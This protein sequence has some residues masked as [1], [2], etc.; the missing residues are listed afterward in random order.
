M[1]TILARLAASVV[2]GAGMSAL[3]ISTCDATARPVCEIAPTFDAG[4]A[5]TSEI[6]VAPP[7]LGSNQTGDG[8]V[9]RPY[10]TIQYAAARAVPGTAVRVHPGSYAGGSFVT[11]V[12]GTPEAPIWIGGF[13]PRPGE[14]PA[15]PIITGGSEGL[16]LV[17]CAY[18]VVH[19]LEVRNVSSNGINSDDGGE[20]DDPTAAHHQVFRSLVIQ[21]IGG[22][23]NQ[24][25]LKLSGVYNFAVIDCEISRCGGAMSGSGIDMVGC[26]DGVIARTF[27]H[28]LSANAVQA[29]GGTTNID[30]T[31][32]RI[33]NA[34]ERALNI[35]GSTGFEFFRP[36]LSKTGPNAEARNI[37]ATANTIL[38]SNAAVAF[39]GAMDCVFAHNT[40]IEPRRWIMRI[41]QETTSSP[42]YVF[43]ACSNNTFASNIVYFQRGQI[44]T[45]VNIGSNTLPA[46]FVFRNNLWYAHDNPAASTPGLP[47]PETGAVVGVDPMLKDVAGGDY[48]ICASSA[49]AGQG[50]S[51]PRVAGD[52]GGACYRSPP[53]IGAF[54]IPEHPAADFDSSGDLGSADFFAFLSAFFLGDPA[55]DFNADG[56]I[57]SQDFFDFLG[58]FI[59]GC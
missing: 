38:G 15:R 7:P 44:S 30:I 4:R 12:R 49:A 29:K 22:T 50:E 42:P 26:H 40:V 56:T 11:D 6:N 55:S 20:Y 47:S 9:A 45:Y 19:D 31:R 21:D 53:S 2:W 59:S 35:G 27:M 33:E 51:P 54:E 32:C 28:D 37:R 14:P 8:S 34:G 39:V 1:R 13:S 5:P 16:H 23:G 52:F 46:T 48:A 24:D 17:R 3:A 18:V 36:P 57:N 58:A 43:D 41:L 10:A 25:G